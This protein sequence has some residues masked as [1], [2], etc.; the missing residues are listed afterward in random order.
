VL[1]KDKLNMLNVF[2]K[3]AI[4]GHDCDWDLLEHMCF[5]DAEWYIDGGNYCQTHAQ[6]VVRILNDNGAGIDPKKIN[7]LDKLKGKR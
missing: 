5:E 4:K 2:I 7:W 1:K 3:K 6:D